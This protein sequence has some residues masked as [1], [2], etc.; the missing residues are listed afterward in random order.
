[1]FQNIKKEYQIRLA[2]IGSL[3]VQIDD[4]RFVSVLSQLLPH[5]GIRFN[6]DRVAAGVAQLEPR[7]SA[8][9]ASTDVKDAVRGAGEEWLY[10]CSHMLEIAGPHQI[11]RENL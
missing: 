10:L 2:D 1:M 3:G 7:G 9:S 6:G 5:S 8:P 4:Q 11:L